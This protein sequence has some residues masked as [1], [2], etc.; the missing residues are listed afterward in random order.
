MKTKLGIG[1]AAAVVIGL[2]AVAHE[3]TYRDEVRAHPP[4]P[5]STA[6]VPSLPDP[7]QRCRRPDSDSEILVTLSWCIEGVCQHQCGIYPMDPEE[8]P[9]ATLKRLLTRTM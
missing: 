5:L 2:T 9:G 7:A 1:I 4:K 3:M 6:Q 8:S